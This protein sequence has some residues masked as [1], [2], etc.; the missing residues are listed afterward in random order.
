MCFVCSVCCCVLLCV[1]VCCCV[2]LCV[3]VCCCVVVLLVCCGCVVC[4]VVVVLLLCCGYKTEKHQKTE[5]KKWKHGDNI[6]GK[7]K[8]GKDTLGTPFS[9]VLPAFSDMGS[10]SKRTK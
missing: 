8:N 3:V 1:V 7:D 5:P 4:C 6:V 9:N 10:L 2:L